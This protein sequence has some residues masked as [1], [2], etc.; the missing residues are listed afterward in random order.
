MNF[1]P[2]QQ[3]LP[4]WLT[5]YRRQWLAGDANAALVATMLLVP[6]ALAY[7]A[8]AGL[9]PH[10]GLYAS[11]LPLI[12]YALFGS[13]MVLSVGPVAVLALMTAS[14]LKPIA[15]PGSPEYLA[16]AVLLALLSGLMLVI[17][18]SLRMGALANLLSHP[19]IGGFVAGAATLIIIGQ[20]R[21][22][23]GIEAQGDTALQLLLAIVEQ[24]P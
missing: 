6:Q 23:L 16:G 11:L 7:A 18:G 19:V 1:K 4:G 3:L 20:V 14:A 12:G 13:S 22:L 5:G 10:I 17:M 21:P 2:I 24:L 8:L 9:P 15:V